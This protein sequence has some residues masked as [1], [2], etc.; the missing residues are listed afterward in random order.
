M[1]KSEE[2]L[3]ALQEKVNAV[4]TRVW[5][6]L[7]KE[8]ADFPKEGQEAFLHAAGAG[9]GGMMF[10]AEKALQTQMTRAAFID[11][12]GRVFDQVKAH[13]G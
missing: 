9:Q 7:N 3:R 6:A 13:A 1:A 10:A 2:E 5:V 12:A 11:L 4:S 8:T